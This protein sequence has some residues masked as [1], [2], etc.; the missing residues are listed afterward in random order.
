MSGLGPE[1]S[2]LLE[3]GSHG[4]EPT[5]ADRERVLAAIAAR[6]AAG[7]A[8]GLA[9][10][11]A[12]ATAAGGTTASAWARLG[13]AAK[14]I[15]AAGLVG[16][17]GAGAASL[18]RAPPRRETPAVSS[19]PHGALPEASRAT[20]MDSTPRSTAEADPPTPALSSSTDA[21]G[22]PAPPR[23]TAAPRRG[24]AIAGDV[25]AEVRLL[26]DAQTAVRDGDA[27]RALALLDEHAR[28]YPKGALGE[29]RDAARVAVLCALGRDDEART[30]ADR[31]L[32]AAPDSPHAGPIRASCAGTPK[33]P[34]A[35]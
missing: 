23:W 7:A 2:A 13:W 8:A 28:R 19:D 33:A 5:P 34:L 14:A 6:L 26:S 18:L 27:A 17:I 30:A 35:P 15:L 3:A 29:E 4:D 16:A 9:A 25:A 20:A 31:F 22:A 1:A 11:A 10:G 12:G 24:P 21:L 32:R